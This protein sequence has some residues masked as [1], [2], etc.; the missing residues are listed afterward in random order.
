MKTLEVVLLTMKIQSPWNR[1]ILTFIQTPKV[2]MILSLIM[3]QNQPILSLLNALA[4]RMIV[5]HKKCCAKLA[6]SFKTIKICLQNSNQY[7]TRAIAFMCYIDNKWQRVGYVVQEC[8][9]H[10]HKALLECQIVSVK[11]CWAKYLVC[12]SRSGPGYYA[13]INVSLRGEWHRDVVR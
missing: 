10:V 11:L 2:T 3:R 1:K 9:E 4:L 12:W 13:G 8:L 5:M 7:D 6:N